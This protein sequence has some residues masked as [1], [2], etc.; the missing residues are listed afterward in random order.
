M[1]PL[2]LI[3]AGVVAISLVW[4]QTPYNAFQYGIVM[5]QLDGATVSHGQGGL[6]PS[7]RHDFSLSNP[8]TWVHAGFALLSG[9]YRG[10]DVAIPGPGFRSSYG[11]L[12]YAAFI[13]PIKGR[14]AF[15]LGVRPYSR[16]TFLLQDDAVSPVIFSGDTLS[17]TKTM[18]G[19]GGISVLLA[20]GSWKIND[21]FS[22]GLRWDFLTGVF[23]EDVTGELAQVFATYRRHFRVRGTLASIFVRSLL[24]AEPF[25][26]TGYGLVQFPVG[27]REIKETDYFPYLPV[28]FRKTLSGPVHRLSLPVQLAGGVA[29]RVSGHLWA[30]MEIHTF[31]IAS[32]RSGQV[33][34]LGGQPADGFRVSVGLLKNA[35]RT[36]E[37]LPGRLHY[38]IGFFEREHY[39]SRRGDALHERGVG[40]GIGI[41][42]GPTENQI[43]VAFRFSSRRGFL[44][45][46][47][48][49]LRDITVGL[50][51]G[52]VWLVK[53][54]RR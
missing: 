49:S 22:L 44:S 50:T 46:D 17:F 12:S 43:D 52:D 30:S 24:F 39:I 15:G 23:D 14:W 38:R 40:F 18:E 2:R 27:R 48:E 51:L 26:T 53:A 3:V 32:D 5:D 41:P 29:S 10:G 7:H 8:A 31:R 11:H 35:D 6:T 16:K 42:F 4:G 25:P 37:S 13:L 45:D 19:S 9:H 33:S 36:S 54:R 28:T 34:S 47:R 1:K 21:R 20:G